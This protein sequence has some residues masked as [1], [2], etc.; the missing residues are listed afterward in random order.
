MDGYAP[1]W[2][3]RAIQA[4]EA[5]KAILNLIV[6]VLLVVGL[7]GC[8]ATSPPATTKVK[9]PTCGYEFAPYAIGP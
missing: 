6:S 1:C 5:M 8:A 2:P 4:E 9:C 7:V 3:D